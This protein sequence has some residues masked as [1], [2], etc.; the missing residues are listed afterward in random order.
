VS[1]PFGDWERS[2][3]LSVKGGVVVIEKRERERERE[4]KESF[5]F[6]KKNSLKANWEGLYYFCFFVTPGKKTRS[7][8]KKPPL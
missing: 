8:I 5:I 1:S 2:R 3:S 4:R 6:K 7:S